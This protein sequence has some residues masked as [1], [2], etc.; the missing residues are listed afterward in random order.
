[1]LQGLRQRRPDG[2]ASKITGV[3]ILADADM[4]KTRIAQYVDI[5]ADD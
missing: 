2:W 5:H 3:Y 4:R 1:M